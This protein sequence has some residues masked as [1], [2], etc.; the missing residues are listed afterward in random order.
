MIALSSRDMSSKFLSFYQ[1]GHTELPFRKYIPFKRPTNGFF[2]FPKGRSFITS[3]VLQVRCG[4]QATSNI[5]AT[6]FISIII[7][8]KNMKWKVSARIPV[9]MEC[10]SSSLLLFAHLMDLIERNCVRN[11]KIWLVCRL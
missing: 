10:S 4:M 11:R 8:F 9:E 6:V 3:V 5:D 1:T 2:P 7:I